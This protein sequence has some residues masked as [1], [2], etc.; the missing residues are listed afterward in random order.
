MG[1]LVSIVIC[2]TAAGIGSSATSSA[3]GGW[4]T[5]INKPTWNPPN[6]IFAPVWT[7]LFLMMAVA[8]WLVWKNAGLKKAKLALGCFVVQL[9]LNTLWSVLFFGLQQPGWA[10]FE[11]AV[12]WASIL[13]TMVLFM[14]HSR[15]AA[16]LL[17]PYLLW[18]SF[19]AFL[20]FTIWQLN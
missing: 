2:F 18:V 17:V 6:W 8:A 7:T 20:N 3:V 9:F 4:Y 19:A 16:I 1:L 13:A 5:E 15:T 14:R 12:L 10:S 11:I